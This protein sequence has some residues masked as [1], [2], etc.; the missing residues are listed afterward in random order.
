MNAWLIGV[1]ILIIVIL[2]ST[3]AVYYAARRTMYLK[4]GTLIKS[5]YSDRMFEIV[6]EEP[7]MVLSSIDGKTR[8][9]IDGW[10]LAVT[11]HKDEHNR[12]YTTMCI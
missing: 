4:F 10:T 2:I 6:E 5:R 3:S 1:A 11:C 9:S 12:W 8:I 7:Q